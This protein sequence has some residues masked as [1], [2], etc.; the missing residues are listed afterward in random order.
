MTTAPDDHYDGEAHGSDAHDSDAHD[1]DAHDSDAHDPAAHAGP[2]DL[3]FGT[4][5]RQALRWR[6]APALQPRVSRSL[7]RALDRRLRRAAR[8]IGVPAAELPGV[9]VAIVDDPEIQRLNAAHM[10]KDRP[11]DVLSFPARPPG[12]EGEAMAALGVPLGDIVLCW[13]AVLRQAAARLPADAPADALAAAALDE[14]TVLAIHGLCHL[15]GH[16]HAGR[17]DGRSMH[18]RERRGLRAAHVADI[19]RPYGLRPHA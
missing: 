7:V 15:L 13:D 2:D 1:S 8:R 16:D 5:H 4:S 12:P 10:G 18:R 11:T 3:S 14:A 17:A 9:S 6:V 19:P